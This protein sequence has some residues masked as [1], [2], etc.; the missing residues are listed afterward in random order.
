MLELRRAVAG[1]A[2]G[3]QA[4]ADH[5]RS[6]RVPGRV[7]RLPR[8]P[9]PDHRHEQDDA[10]PR[11]SEPSR[12]GAGRHRLR[13]D[14]G[15]RRRARGAV[16][17]ALP[18]SAAALRPRFHVRRFQGMTMIS[19]TT[20]ATPVVP[21]S[22]R[23][24]PL[25]LDEVSITGGFWARRQAVNGTATLEH[26]GHRLESEGWIGNFDRAAAGTLPEGRRGREFSDSEVYKY[27][28]ALAWEIGRTDDPALDARF[29]A[30]VDRIA[31]AQEPDGY[32]NTRFGRIGQEPRWS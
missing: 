17:R 25:G 3:G 8:A 16:H 30:I 14:R 22:G 12:A 32:L 21:A 19:T 11:R 7:E 4:G 13:R 26:I 15:R 1:A 2:S 18:R 6:V 20:P 5:G 27:L 9:H 23:L 24:R 31:R 29:R 10:P 28:E